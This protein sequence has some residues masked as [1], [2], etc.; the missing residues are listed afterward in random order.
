IDKGWTVEIAIPLRALSVNDHFRKPRN[1]AMWRINFS[2]VEW[3][4]DV[5]DGKY[6]KQTDTDGHPRPE[7]NW[8]WSPQ[9]V[10]NM[11]FPERWGYLL[12]SDNPSGNT[13]STMPYSE[14]QK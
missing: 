4:T 3:D 11:H 10:I 5:K 13:T 7:H 8:V 9:G 12:F 1:G 6:V 2:R 14:D